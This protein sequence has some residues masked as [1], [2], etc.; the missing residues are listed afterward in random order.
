MAE[1]LPPLTTDEFAT[2][3]VNPNFKTVL[4]LGQAGDRA[5]KVA[6]AAQRLLPGV[7]CYLAK[8]EAARELRALHDVPRSRPTA[9]FGLEG[10]LSTTLTK[11]RAEDFLDVAEAVAEA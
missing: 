3:L 11:K 7:R 6:K 9:I 1:I 5:W 4:V 8:G 10:E 2:A